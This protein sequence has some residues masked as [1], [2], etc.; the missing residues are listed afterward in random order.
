[1]LKVLQLV[2]ILPYAYLFYSRNQSL[3][4]DVGEFA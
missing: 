3:V 4:N 1:M 2:E